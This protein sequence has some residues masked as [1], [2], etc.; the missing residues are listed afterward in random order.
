LPPEN[1]GLLERESVVIEPGLIQRAATPIGAIVFPVFREGTGE[2]LERVPTGEAAFKL[3]RDC[4]NF[5]DHKAEAVSRAV[6]LA[7]TIPVYS[8][9]YSSS[10]DAQHL[11]DSRL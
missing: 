8:L 3:I 10:R 4:T 6:S 7:R 1:F 5:A 9:T 11:L 2:E